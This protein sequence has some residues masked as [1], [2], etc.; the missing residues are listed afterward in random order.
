MTISKFLRKTTIEKPPLAP[1][2]SRELGRRL[3]NGFFRPYMGIEISTRGWGREL[4][5]LTIVVSLISAL[6]WILRIR[7]SSRSH[8]DTH[9]SCTFCNNK[10]QNG[11]IL[12]IPVWIDSVCVRCMDCL[13]WTF[14]LCFCFILLTLLHQVVSL[15]QI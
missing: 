1:P 3:F 15:Y 4:T 7:R 11:G 9:Q 12:K 14:V 8:G 5:T 13:G 6:D 2:K 10:S